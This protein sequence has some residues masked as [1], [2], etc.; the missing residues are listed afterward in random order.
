[1]SESGLTVL[2]WSAYRSS[3]RRQISIGEGSIHYGVLSLQQVK[4]PSWACA[5]SDLLCEVIV[6]FRKQQV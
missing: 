1:M 2:L 3:S 6:L 5:Y 4:I